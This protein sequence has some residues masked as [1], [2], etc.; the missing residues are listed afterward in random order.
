MKASTR[1]YAWLKLLTILHLVEQ[2]IFGMEDLH[3]FQH[4]IAV[5]ENRF[6]DTNG[7]IAAL[8]T[9]SASLAALAVHFILK[10]GLARFITMFVLGL[11]TLGEFHHFIETMRVGHYTGGT[12]TAVPSIVCGVLF[13]RALV[14]EYR[15]FKNV[16][17]R[18]ALQLPVA[19]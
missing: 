10:G 1:L 15:P 7:S 3:E 13:L 2:L 4:L 17:L 16:R 6:G 8:V 5:Y 14:Q 11:P 12:V 9:I 19:A 18:E